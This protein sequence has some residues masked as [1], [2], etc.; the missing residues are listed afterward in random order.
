MASNAVCY[1]EVTQSK[2]HGTI[3]CRAGKMHDKLMGVRMHKADGTL[4]KFLQVPSN[5]YADDKAPVLMV[6]RPVRACCLA[7]LK[8]C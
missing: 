8:L 2:K 4:E 3:E 7:S 1:G 5:L 6:V